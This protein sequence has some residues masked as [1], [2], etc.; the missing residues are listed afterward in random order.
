MEVVAETLHHSAEHIVLA[1]T[2]KEEHFGETLPQSQLVDV[3]FV[4]LLGQ[5]VVHFSNAVHDVLNASCS[6]E[7]QGKVATSKGGVCGVASCE[8]VDA[9]VLRSVGVGRVAYH[10]IPHGAFHLVAAL[11]VA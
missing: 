4:A 2:H 8:H 5:L 9:D 1:G 6:V 7:V 11:G 10:Y 3:A